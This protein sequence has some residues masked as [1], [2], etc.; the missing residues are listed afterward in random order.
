MHNEFDL[1]KKYFSFEHHRDDVLLAGGDDCASVTVAANQQLMITSDTL[2]SGVHFP[3]KTSAS[4]IAYKAVM[5]NL[6]DLAAMGATPAWLSLAITI[7]EVDDNWLAEFSSSMQQLLERF[8]VCLIGGDTTKGPLS[9]TIQ[10]MGFCDKDKS[11]QR[12]QAKLGDLIFVTGTLGDAAI[13]LLALQNNLDDS[14]L[15]GCIERLNRPEARVAFAQDL[16]AVANCA[17]DLSDGLVADMGH[18]ISASKCGAKISLSKIPVSSAAQYYFDCYADK[19]TDWSTLLASG[20]DY[21]LCFTV[22]TSNAPMVKVL[23]EKHQLRVTCV[24][25]V[26]ESMTLDFFDEKNNRVSFDDS[27]YKHF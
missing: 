6:S 10:A 4:D 23:S 14:K 26:N 5:V 17:I 13:G 24:G 20:D 16:V 12:S 11:L 8:N 19:I 9:I 21:E 27:G 25:E 15:N 18:I 1:I 3:E 2:I 22:S 7:P